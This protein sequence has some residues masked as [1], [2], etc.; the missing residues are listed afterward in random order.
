MCTLLVAGCGKNETKSVSAPVTQPEFKAVAPKISLDPQPTE[1][2][3]VA[4]DFGIQV[5]VQETIGSESKRDLTDQITWKIEPAGI[6]QVDAG[7]VRPI[8]A[9]IGTLT[10]TL[11]DRRVEIPL[12]VPDNAERTWS[13]A[14]DIV[15]LLT[16]AGC[17]TGGCHGRADGQNGFHL[18]LFGYDPA[19]DHDAITR[20]DG[21]RRL[22]PLAPESSLLLLKST[23][24]MPHVGGPRIQVGSPEYM[25]LLSWIKEGTPLA[26]GKTHG[27]MTGLRVEP[28]VIQLEAPGP[29]QLRVLAKYSD[30]YERDVTRQAIYKT[31]DDSA[32][33]IDNKGRVKLLRRAETD[34]IV[35]YGSHVMARRVSTVINPELKYD[36]VARK[37][38]NFIDEELFKRLAAL[39]VPPSQTSTDTAFLRRLTLDLTGQQPRPEQVRE[40]LDDK[41]PAKR[42][43]L[44]ERLLK[45]RDFVRFWSIKLGD[46]LEITTGRP[47]LAGTASLYQSWVAAR[48]TDNTPWDKFVRT[49]LTSVG[50][51]ATKEDA[52]ASYALDSLDPMVAAEKTAQRFLGLRMRCAHCHDHP[53][54]VWTQ[55]NYFGLAATFAKVDRGGGM[56]PNPAMMNRVKVG[57][58]PKGSLEH[59]RTHKPAEPR[60]LDGKAIK[61]NEKDDPRKS[62]VDWMTAPENPY[63]SRAMSNWVWAQF[64]GK[65]IVDPPD[66]LSA[67]NPAVHPELLDALAKSFVE[68]KYDLRQLIRTIVSSE[69]YGLSAATVPG[70]ESDIRLFSHQIP[71]PLTAH[72]MADAIAQV[73]DIPNRFRDRAPG[74]RAID[75][76]DPATPSPILETFGRCGRINGCATVQTPSIS[77]RQSLLLIG[78]DLIDSKVSSLN[79][80]LANMLDLKPS[81]EEVVENLYLRT[82]CRPPTGEE[83]S[84][85]SAELKSTGSFRDAAEDLFWA[86]L[87]SREFAFNH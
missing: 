2:K 82:V 8:K 65:G 74:T 42:S 46:M 75:V 10:A 63:F 53:F 33:T 14:D 39:K 68:N 66:D 3:F 51:P 44:A 84:R 18:S 71:R 15:P 32:A 41:D 20:Q 5:R 17:N 36:Y 81:P 4:G 83:T 78:G 56:Q 43:K 21:G 29:Q 64:F 1:L 62:F 30:G 49:L 19:S 73:T 85:W 57:I 55:D 48:L 79:G 72:Q 9:G 31:N 37:R 50:D 54:D 76:V 34:L 77:L 13:M 16:R 28:A 67:S 59:L 38:N 26:R 58:N 12:T 86:L 24:S 70:N 45:E 87:N 52:A 35:R 40:F 69:A 80:Y 6:A 23:G 22:A 11:D 25:S 61:I 47:E 60:L 27:S 7:Y